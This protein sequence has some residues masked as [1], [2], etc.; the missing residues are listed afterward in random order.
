VLVQCYQ[1][2]KRGRGQAIRQ[3]GVRWAISFEHPMRNEPIRCALPFYLLSRL[4]KRECFGL[5]EDIGDEHV[6]VAVQRIEGVRE[7][8]KVDRDELGSLMDQ[9]IERVLTVGSGLAPVDRPS[10]IIYFISVY[11]DVLTIALHR[12]LLEI[13][14]KA[15][16]ILLVRK[17]SNCVSA[18]K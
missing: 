8:D 2:A 16:E 14:G 18:E 12:E 13:S 11:R 6:V 5:S 1:F 3:K 15:L 9:L 17:N 4:A 7:G 10:L